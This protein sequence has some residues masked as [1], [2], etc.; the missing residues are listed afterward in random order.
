MI[1]PPEPTLGARL[2]TEF[3]TLRELSS[4]AV[5]LWCVFVIA[6]AWALAWGGPAIVRTTWRLGSDPRRR[7]GL[8]ASALRIVGLLIGVLGLL[9]PVITRAPL[10]GS[11]MI[12]IVLAL[13]GL[14]APMQLRNLASGLSLATRSRLR[15]GELVI[16]GALEGTV[17]DIGLLRVSLRT[18]DGGI[19][20]VPAADFERQAVTVGS[21]HAAIPI[22]AR[23]RVGPEFDDRSLEQLRRALWLSPYRRADSDPQLVFDGEAGRVEVRLDTWAAS[24]AVEVERHL[25]AL[26]LELTRGQPSESDAPDEEVSP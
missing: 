9:R 23:A 14:I 19:T 6:V 18:V 3:D 20:H 7:L 21:R 26:L 5:L 4:L 11:A 24:S 15:E 25:R 16:I 1:A 17:R 2:L 8:L 12:V 10:L 22:E 13:A